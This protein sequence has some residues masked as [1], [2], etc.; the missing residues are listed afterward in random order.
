MPDVLEVQATT[1]DGV[2]MAVRHRDL[3]IFG[4]QF[5]PR[6]R[7]YPEGASCSR[8]SST[9]RAR[10]RSRVRRA[11]PRRWWPR[12]T[13]RPE[14]ALRLPRSN[15]S[16]KRIA[17]GLGQVLTEDAAHLVMSKVMDGEQRQSQISALVVGVHEGRDR[18]RDRRFCP[19]DARARDAGQAA[20]IRVDRHV[21]HRG[22]WPAHLQRYNDHGVRR[23]G[24][25]GAG[26]QARQQSGV[27]GQRSADVL[28]ALGVDITLD[29]TDMARCIDEAG[30]GLPVRAVAARE[31]AA[32][33]PVRR[34]IGIRTVFP[35]TSDR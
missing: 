22:R 9:L 8:T 2:L 11:V 26:R 25:G 5:H 35:D 7:A 10:C 18:R 19:G 21:R 15:R 24:R 1:P 6:E 34:E 14:S 3:P 12:R 30:V 23:R 17:C 28:E 16:P 4:V 31:H 32:C 33:G 20:S 29:A 13:A 27:L